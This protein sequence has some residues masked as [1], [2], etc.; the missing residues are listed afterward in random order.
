MGISDEVIIELY[1]PYCG[2][3][4]PN[5]SFQ[6]K[7]L[8]PS[9]NKYTL[10]QALIENQKQGGGWLHLFFSCKGCNHAGELEI[11]NWYDLELEKRIR[12]ILEKE[13]EKLQILENEFDRGKN[14]GR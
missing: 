7:D 10:I 4:L 6:T 3:K 12:E 8:H 2:K 1:C 13:K 14:N 11:G 5:K 9:M